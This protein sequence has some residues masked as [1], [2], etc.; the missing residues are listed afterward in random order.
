M[1]YD[2]DYDDRD[3][4]GGRNGLRDR[5]GRRP[6]KKGSQMRGG[7]AIAFVLLLGI[8]LLGYMMRFDY[9]W[10]NNGGV[11]VTDA[12]GD[13]GTQMRDVILLVFVQTDG[14]D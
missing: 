1:D 12:R 14:A 4:R 3:D 5:K 11:L 13:R 9:T 6:P 2:D 7:Y 10:T 8:V